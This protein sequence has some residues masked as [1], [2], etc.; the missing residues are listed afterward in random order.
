V[1]LDRAS[2]IDVCSRAPVAHVAEDG[3]YLLLYD[4]KPTE[5]CAFTMV[6]NERYETS[7]LG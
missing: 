4:Q 5:K 3:R 6:D 7:Q 1:E 2:A